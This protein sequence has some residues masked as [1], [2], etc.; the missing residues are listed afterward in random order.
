MEKNPEK[1]PV[2]ILF[3]GQAGAGKDTTASA[4]KEVLEERGQ[5]VLITHYADLLK[6]ICRAFLGWDGQKDE[7]GRA[8][9]QYVGTEVFRERDPDI[10]VRFIADVVEAFPGTWDFVLIPD[11]RFPNEF[12]FMEERGFNPILVEIRRPFLKS[13]LT[14]GQKK[15]ASETAMKGVIPH[16]TIINYE[17]EEDNGKCGLKGAAEAIVKEL[18]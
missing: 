11:C 12:T 18:L 9:L 17:S 6:Y 14:D 1:K 15:H 10:W 3:S 13:S 8:M 16:Y 5:K 4:M 2:M 7:A